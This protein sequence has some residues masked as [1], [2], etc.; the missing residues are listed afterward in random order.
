MNRLD[1]RFNKLKAE[2]KKALIVFITAGD[3]SLKKNKDLASSFE[4]DGVDV[5]E[6]GVPFSDPLADGPV[7]QDSSQRS[8]KKGTTLKMILAL[9]KDIRRQSRIP[10]VLMSYLNPILSY[11]LEKFAKDASA[12]G[13]DGV[14]LPDVPVEEGAS[15][16]RIFK[17]RRLKLIYLLAPTSTPERMKKVAKASSG[18]I[19]FVSMTGVTGAKN[20]ARQ[21]VAGHIRAVKRFTRLP[22]CVGFGILTPAQAAEMSKISDGIIVGSAVVRALHENPRCSAD[23]FSRR[24]ILPLARAVKGSV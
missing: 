13:V 23:D 14:I 2:K 16:A 11:G 24:F 18:F 15:I 5:I 7:I 12:A 9:A 6:L 1:A 3:P 21:D 8:L 4:R 19:Y 17:D 10:L 20:S 22:V